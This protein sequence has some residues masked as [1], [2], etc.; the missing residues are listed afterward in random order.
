MR[1]RFFPYASN[2]K[3]SVCFSFQLSDAIEGR[4]KP[5]Q[6]MDAAML[7]MLNMADPEEEESREE[8]SRLAHARVDPLGQL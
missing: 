6:P 7:E 4:K 5:S 1:T 8:E 3:K 2:L